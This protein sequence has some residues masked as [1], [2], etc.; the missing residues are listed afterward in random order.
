MH[1]KKII[2]VIPARYQSTR[3]PGK[4]L[5]KIGSK[6]MIELVYLRCKDSKLLDELVIATDDLRVFREVQRFGGIAVMTSPDIATG[7]DR[8][9]NAIEQLFP[10]AQIVVNIQGDEPLIDPAVIDTCIRAILNESDD[11]VCSTPVKAITNE[12]DLLSPNCVKV[13]FNNEGHALYF[14]RSPIP[15]VRKQIDGFNHY[16]HIGLYAYKND[17]L[18]KFIKMNQEPLEIVE[19]LEQLRILAN[20]YSIKCCIV[21]Y[22]AI[23]VDTPEDLERVRQILTD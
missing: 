23:G 20:G 9:Y 19:S 10:T 1:D 16:K 13:V 7:T 6:T 21:D 22:D 18:K 17:F 8:C 4:P 2:G 15:F 3:L 11:I 5:V 14:S 12:E